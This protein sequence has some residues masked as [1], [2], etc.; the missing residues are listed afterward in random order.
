MSM[1]GACPRF[2]Y[3]ISSITS[4]MDESDEEFGFTSKMYR[5][6]FHMEYDWPCLSFDVLR[7]GLGSDQSVRTFPHTAWF[8]AATQADDQ[9]DE[10]CDSLYVTKIS[11]LHMTKDDDDIEDE[12]ALPN[13]V[14]NTRKSFHPGPAT[15]VRSMPQQSEIVATW[16]E[17]Q[18]VMIW[19]VKAAI[20]STN[21]EQG[22]SRETKVNAIFECVVG[23]VGYGLAWS[24]QNKGRLA[25][26]QDSGV[27]TLWE[28]AQA[29][30]T[31]LFAIEAHTASVE[32]IVF[33]PSEA[34]IFA[35][36]S[37]DGSI[38]VWDARTPGE[39]VMKFL[40][41]ETD[42]NVIDWNAMQQNLIVSGDDAGVI[43]VWDLAGAQT[44]EGVASGEVTYHDSPITSIEWNPFDESEFAA[45]CED[46]RVTIWDLSAEPEEPDQKMEDIPDQ[47][48][49]EHPTE[50][51]KE[52]HYHP[53]IKSMLAITGTSFEVI[54][55]DI[56][57]ED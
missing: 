20:D 45:A 56:Q 44:R 12:S 49:F 43:R 1:D 10:E 39:P 15:R 42:V 2:S 52:L 19:N 4:T 25:V 13:A 33:S 54:I 55:P 24:R 35:S 8:V 31:R 22:L 18:S 46:G 14:V 3:H 47:L 37:C 16:S 5:L 28:D 34:D 29:A 50:E 57:T 11:N 41:S 26:G 53:Q 38:A 48:M 23:D 27:I 9:G 7:D 21:T 30:F 36:C 40:A 32:D 17:C 51:P 6:F